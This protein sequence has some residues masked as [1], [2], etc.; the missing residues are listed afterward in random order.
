MRFKSFLLAAAAAVAIS[1]SAEAALF[2]ITG[3]DKLA[4]AAS[5]DVIDNATGSI[6]DNTG[7]SPWFAGD[8]AGIFMNFAGGYAVEW[9]FAGSESGFTNAFSTTGNQGGPVQTFSVNE[10]DGVNDP[11]DPIHTLSASG[12]PGTVGFGGT[13]VVNYSGAAG[14]AI[15]FSFTKTSGTDVERVNGDAENDVLGNNGPIDAVTIIYSYAT[16]GVSGF[17]LSLT[18]N[19]QNLFVIAFD[20]SGANNDDNHDDFVIVG[21]VRNAG[22]IDVPVPAALPL[23]AGGLGLLGLVGARRRRKN[24]AAA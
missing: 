12:L 22:L 20:D 17:E 13:S 6:Q 2:T 21:A 14:A 8:G 23:L 4:T 9:L 5:N 15:P 18:P 7:G 1:G 3:P 24:A 16:V 10:A 19:E 11:F